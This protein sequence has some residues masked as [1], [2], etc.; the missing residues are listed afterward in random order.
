MLA[1]DITPLVSD[2]ACYYHY[3]TSHPRSSHLKAEERTEL[4]KLLTTISQVNCWG[5]DPHWPYFCS[6][7]LHPRHRTSNPT[8]TPMDTPTLEECGVQCMLDHDVIHPSNSPWSSSV[9]M[10]K[11]K[12]GSWRFCIDYHKLNA[13]TCHNAYPLPR[14]DATLDS[15]AGT[16]YFT[17]LD[18]ASE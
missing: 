14:I 7:T 15:L 11:K 13:V 4:T 8:A 18:L 12:D 1:S 3:Y 9:I 2:T 6:Q 10:A 5:P 16:T 17:T